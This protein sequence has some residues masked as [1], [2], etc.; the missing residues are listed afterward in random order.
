MEVVSDVSIQVGVDKL[1]L[2]AA[3]QSRVER[4]VRQP[5]GMLLSTG[6]TGS[7]KTT[8]QYISMKF[9]PA[10][11]MNTT[12]VISISGPLSPFTV[13]KWPMLAL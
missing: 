8:T 12:M 9:V 4:L 10:R 2:D 13:V 1:G 5:N 7:R 6:P 3:M 11:S